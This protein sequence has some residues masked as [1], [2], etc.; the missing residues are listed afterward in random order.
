MILSV[1]HKPGKLTYNINHFK[2]VFSD[3]I[4]SFD[5]FIPILF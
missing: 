3:V 2:A 4:I 1:F 5:K